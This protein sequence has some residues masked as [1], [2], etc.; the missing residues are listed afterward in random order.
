MSSKVAVL[1]AGS[2]GSALANVLVENGHQ[3]NIW[4]R[5]EKQKN[6]INTNHTNE[7][8]LPEFKFPDELV[9][10][11]DLKQA[12]MNA[13]AILVVIPTNGIRQLARKL[14]DTLDRKVTI[15]H[16]SKG[17]ERETHKRISVILNEELSAKKTEGIVALSGPSHAEEVI[18]HDLTTITAASLN[19]ERAKFVQKLFLNDYFR[20]YTN[21][22]IIGVEIGAALKN[23]IAIGAGVIAGLGYGDNAKAGLVTRG[24]AE[25]SRLGVEMGADPL[26][27]MGLSGVG[28]LIVTCTSPHSRNWRAGHQLGEGKA[29]KTVLSNMGMVVEGVSTT[30]AAF[31]LAK[32]H[33]IEMPIT[34]AIYDVLYNDAEVKQ[35]ISHLMQREGKAE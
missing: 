21:P 18:N 2:W 12:V 30:Q 16:A 29:I 22:D 20:V 13:E 23:I 4:T 10:T 32:E 35:V 6:E 11:T 25:I 5:E 26:T 3:V 8:Y 17:L 27:F 34:E 33:A 1:G 14:N 19:L 31:E 28:D 24:L 15:I 7:H 9:A